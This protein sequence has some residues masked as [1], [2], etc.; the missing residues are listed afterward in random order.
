[1]K[2]ECYCGDEHTTK[3]RQG[4]AHVVFR[5]H[6]GQRWCQASEHFTTGMNCLACWVP[7]ISLVELLE[8]ES[9]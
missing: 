5:K 2:F 7:T 8:Q 3:G 9:Y 4:K 6:A 1:M